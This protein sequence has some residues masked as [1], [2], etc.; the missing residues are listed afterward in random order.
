MNTDS[1]WATGEPTEEDADHIGERIAALV[2]A[3]VLTQ[4]VRGSVADLIK[5]GEQLRGT[6]LYQV[7]YNRFVEVF[8][9]LMEANTDGMRARTKMATSL[10]HEAVAAR[11]QASEASIEAALSCNIGEAPKIQLLTKL[12]EEL[13]GAANKIYSPVLENLNKLVGTAETVEAI[14]TIQKRAQSE[15]EDQVRCDKCGDP[16]CKDHTSH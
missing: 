8:Q 2:A 7:L 10:M 5:V 1:P 3:E 13:V 6:E 16:D 11:E 14:R 15:L 12:S 9:E 4:P